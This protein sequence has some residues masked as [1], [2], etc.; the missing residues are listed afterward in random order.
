MP[1]STNPT[2]TGL[3]AQVH[4]AATRRHVPLAPLVR[5]A[6]MRRQVGVEVVLGQVDA[7][8]VQVDVARGPVAHRRQRPVAF[9]ARRVDRRHVPVT[10]RLAQHAAK[11]VQRVRAIEVVR[12]GGVG[13]H[14]VDGP[15]DVATLV[16]HDVHVVEVD[17]GG[18]VSQ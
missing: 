14:V 3:R 6:E 10:P 16:V 11:R 8:A 1:Q 2:R 7:R 15:Q 5:V 12:A 9:L 13:H 18:E 4:R 17:V